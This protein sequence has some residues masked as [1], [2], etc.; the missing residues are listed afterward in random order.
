MLYADSHTADARCSDNRSSSERRSREDFTSTT[1]TS[2]I[3]FF[4][5]APSRLHPQQRILASRSLSD[6]PFF[7]FSFSFSFSTASFSSFSLPRITSNAWPRY[8]RSTGFEWSIKASCHL[9]LTRSFL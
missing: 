3:V 6:T 7:F 2:S 5:H 8:P 4:R 9:F 1:S